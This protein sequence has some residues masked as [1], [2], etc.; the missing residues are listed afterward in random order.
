M[1]AEAL[2]ARV[3]MHKEYLNTQ[4]NTPDFNRGVD[5]MCDFMVTAFCALIQ[6]EEKQDRE[7]EATRLEVQIERQEDD[8]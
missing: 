5:H 6:A 7:E 1:E 8:D 2:L 4:K 3:E